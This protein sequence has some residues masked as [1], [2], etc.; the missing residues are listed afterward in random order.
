MVPDDQVPGWDIAGPGEHSTRV[1]RIPYQVN[2]WHMRGPPL[3]ADKAPGERRIMVVGDS[4]PFGDGLTWEQTF[5]AALAALRQARFPGSTYQGGNCAAPGHSS[6]Q[7][8]AKLQHHC[9]P[10][11]ADLVLLANQFS[12]ASPVD[13]TDRDWFLRA[14]QGRPDGPLDQLAL[15]RLLRNTWWARVVYARGLPPASSIPVQRDVARGG[16]V[17]RVPLD[18]YRENLLEM[19]ELLRPTGA[20]IVLLVLPARVDL[21]GDP[22]E[23]AYTAHRAALHALGEELGLEVIDGPAHFAALDPQG[24]WF[25]DEIHPSAEQGWKRSPRSR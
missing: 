7:S 4:T 15:Y 2:A 18:Q 3:A 17:A 19:V 16:Q 11:G 6:L 13:Q 22:V 12:D 24:D 10:F 14:R 1:T 8:L 20:R 21:G 23:R 25:Q 9:L 5:T